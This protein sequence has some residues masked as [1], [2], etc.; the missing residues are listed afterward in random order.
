MFVARM[1]NEICGDV[2]S[3]RR[4]DVWRE[5]RVDMHAVHIGDR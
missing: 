4:G 3:A 5:G 1:Q 2:A